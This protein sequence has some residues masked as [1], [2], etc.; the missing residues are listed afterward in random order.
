M[1][2]LLLTGVSAGAI[3]F[4][5]V[6]ASAADFRSPVSVAQTGHYFGLSLGWASV[7]GRIDD[8]DVNYASAAGFANATRGNAFLLG[9]KLGYDFRRNGPL[10][11]GVEADVSAI[12]GQNATCS[13]AGCVDT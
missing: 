7:G 10:V 6:E 4:G 12:F 2:T 9:G 11:L 5:V 1:R 3:L 8:P 13:Q